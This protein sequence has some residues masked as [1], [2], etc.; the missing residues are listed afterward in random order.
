LALFEA[1]L[2]GLVLGN[3]HQNV[4]HFKTANGTETPATLAADL[5]DKW[6]QQIKTRH[7]GTLV[8]NGISV[9]Q[10]GTTTAPFTLSIAITGSGD[11]SANYTP[12]AAFVVQIR[13]AFAGR[14]GH[15]RFYLGAVHPGAYVNGI[16]TST[17]IS[18]WATIISTLMGW[19]GPSG[20]TPYQLGVLKRGSSDSTDFHP[21]TALVLR[22]SLGVQRRRNYGVGI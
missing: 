1:T 15:G 20:T 13:T 3:A 17:T 11:T 22:S 12:F 9:R 16:L 18:D 2:Q 4:L 5:R 14:H 19:Y 6:L 7:G 8:W 10:L 21:C